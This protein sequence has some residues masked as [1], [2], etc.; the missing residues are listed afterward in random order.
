MKGKTA[1]VS[2]ERRQCRLAGAAET[3]NAGFFT[4]Q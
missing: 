4:L 1:F 3:A 2:G